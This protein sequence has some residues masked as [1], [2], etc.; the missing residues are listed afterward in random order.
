M[1]KLD[2]SQKPTQ[3]E[4]MRLAAALRLGRNLSYAE[5]ARCVGMARG[6]IYNIF[7]GTYRTTPASA[8]KIA[9]VLGVTQDQFLKALQPIQCPVSANVSS[10]SHKT[11]V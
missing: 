8:A 5:I 7:R 3:V 10:R 4:V 1:T 6:T 9:K 2:A 11:R